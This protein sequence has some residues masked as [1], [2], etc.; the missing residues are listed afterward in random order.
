[1]ALVALLVGHI[2]VVGLVL[3]L[4]ARLVGVGDVGL[5]RSVL[6]AGTASLATVSI[7]FLSIAFLTPAGAMVGV[8]VALA[9]TLLVIREIFGVSYGDAMRVWLVFLIAFIGVALLLG[10]V[11][12]VAV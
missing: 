3:W 9:M 7:V 10:L 1:M 12:T 5:G 6:T 4:S 2:G 11:C 8:P